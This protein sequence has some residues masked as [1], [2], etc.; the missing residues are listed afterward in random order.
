MNREVEI[1]VNPGGGSGECTDIHIDAIA[2]ERV[3]GAQQVTCVVEVKAAGT[4]S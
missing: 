4:L 2:G 1:R 3:E